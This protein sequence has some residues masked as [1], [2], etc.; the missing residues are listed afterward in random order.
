[1]IFALAVELVF[2]GLIWWTSTKLLYDN[3]FGEHTLQLDVPVFPFR[4]LW[5]LGLLL[6]VLVILVEFV[7]TVK[8]TSK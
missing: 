2:W 8:G 3:G 1:L 7:D 5:V 4:L 6:F